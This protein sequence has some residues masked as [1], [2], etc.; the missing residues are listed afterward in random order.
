MPL[1]IVSA[2]DV[3]PAPDIAFR[4]MAVMLTEHMDDG[5]VLLRGVSDAG[6]GLVASMAATRFAE[7]AH[8]E[9]AETERWWTP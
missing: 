9:F 5:R 8:S 6:M 3:L 7:I 1:K 2:T 4:R